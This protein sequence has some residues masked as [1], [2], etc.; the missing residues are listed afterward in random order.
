MGLLE[1]LANPTVPQEEEVV[2]HRHCLWC[3]SLSFTE[4]AE[5]DNLK[6]KSLAKGWMSSTQS[7]SSAQTVVADTCL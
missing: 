6:L 7:T 3:L 2:C 1:I 4:E 5:A